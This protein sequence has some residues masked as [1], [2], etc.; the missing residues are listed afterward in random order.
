MTRTS[1][2]VAAAIA[3]PSFVCSAS[4]SAVWPRV[5]VWVRRSV[6]SPAS[7]AR[8][9]AAWASASVGYQLVRPAGE[10]GCGEH[11]RGDDGGEDPPH[12]GRVAADYAG[13]PWRPTG[14]K[15]S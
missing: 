6:V 15:P 10:R 13:Q 5:H 1:L 4:V 9:V 14:S 8:C 7:A 2:K 12:G 3:F 11:Q